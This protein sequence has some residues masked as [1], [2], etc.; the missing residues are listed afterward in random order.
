MTEF[1]K[2]AIGR[3]NCTPLATTLKYSMPPT[4]VKPGFL[5]ELRIRRALR[6]FS[7]E[8]AMATES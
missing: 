8:P 3:R 5:T 1:M 7:R 6:R 4:T 2:S